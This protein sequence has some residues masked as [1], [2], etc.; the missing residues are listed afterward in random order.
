M[1]PDLIAWLER[2]SIDAALVSW[3]LQIGPLLRREADRDRMASG[4][5]EI[6]G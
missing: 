1:F 4:A 6:F 2:Q 5:G 3:L